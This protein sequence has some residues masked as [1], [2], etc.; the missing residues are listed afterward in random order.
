MKKTLFILLTYFAALLQVS[1]EVG[2]TFS[3]SYEGQTLNYTIIDENDKQVSVSNS[4]VEGS[5]VIPES[6]TKDDYDYKVVEIGALAFIENSKLINV[7]I[8][9]TVASIGGSAFAGCTSLASIEIP[10]SVTAISPHTFHSCTNLTSAE[11][12]NSVISR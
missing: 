10:N 7:T 6:V 3:Y 9:N 4:S 11:I 1:A 2:D 5:L 8:P 12:P